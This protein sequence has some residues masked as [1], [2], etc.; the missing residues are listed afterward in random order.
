MA[1]I[2]RLLLVDDHELFRNGLAGLLR[3]QEDM[4]VVGEASDG[5]E[6]LIKAR[7]LMPDVVLMDIDM[8]VLN[9]LEATRS[10]AAEMPYVKIV[11]LTVHEE[12][13]QLFA[14]IKAGA[15]G[16]L[17]KNIR[18]AEMLEM[19]RGIRSGRGPNL[20]LDGNPVVT[21]VCP[22]TAARRR[23]DLTRESRIA[24]CSCPPS[25]RRAGRLDA[26]RTGS[27]RTCC[28]ACDQ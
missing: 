7:E 25:S 6:A 16:Y 18:M 11:I 19:L 22:V 2:L 24:G 4:Q 15:Q 9:G 13:E 28:Q 23:V 20:S 3:Y 8:P 21:R 5:Q 10:I 12:E 14:A 17:L 1:E 26:P 27:T